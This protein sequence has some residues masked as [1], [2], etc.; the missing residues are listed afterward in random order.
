VNEALLVPVDPLSSPKLEEAGSSNTDAATSPTGLETLKSVITDPD[1]KFPAELR[2]NACSLI[3]TLAKNLPQTP[4]QADDS[5]KGR[6]TIVAPL[7]EALA[8]LAQA[9][10]TPEKLRHAAKWAN[11]ACQ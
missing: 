4:T 11:E 1:N 7:R 5:H 9:E 10:S 6:E 2:A 3:G 8:A